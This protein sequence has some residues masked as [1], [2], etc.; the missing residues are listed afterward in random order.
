MS[1]DKI[2]RI[3]GKNIYSIDEWLSGDIQ[4][5]IVGLLNRARLK[6]MIT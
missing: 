6:T 1:I 5:D 3:K 2:P 4:E